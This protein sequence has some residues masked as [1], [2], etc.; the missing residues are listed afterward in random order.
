[1]KYSDEFKAKVLLTLG[2]SEDIKK[3][4]DNGSEWLGR[5]LDDSRQVS[6]SPEEVI[7]ACESLNL[8]QL[9]NRAKRQLALKELYREWSKMYREQHKMSI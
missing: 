2:D 9:Y 1:M 8:Q 6:I 5:I 7:E 3:M 4:L